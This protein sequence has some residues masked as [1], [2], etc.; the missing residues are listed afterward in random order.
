MPRITVTWI[1]FATLAIAAV[2]P[3]PRLGTVVFP[4]TGHAA[5]HRAFVEGVA[6]LHSFG[7]EQA[8]ESFRAA[9]KI[10][11]HFVMAYWGEAMTHNHP[12]WHSQDVEAGR[13]AL[14]ALAPTP[15]ARAAMAAT[16][17]ERGYLHAVDVLFGSG[18]DKIA[19]DRAYASAMKDLAASYPEDLEAQCFYALALLGTVPLGDRG[20]AVQLEAGAIAE[21]VL[22][23][24]A[25]HP[26]A[27]HLVIH[28]YDDPENAR[29]A[30]SAAHTY[31]HIAPDASHARHMPA[32]IFLQLGM[33][34]EAA[35]SDEAA[36]T[37]S[38][39]WVARQRFPLAMRDFH[40][41][42]WW[43]YELL[44]QGRFA[45]A[46]TTFAPVE[47]A[48]AQAASRGPSASQAPS[49]PL[50]EPDAVA[51]PDAMSLRNDL[52]SI[53][54]FY[55]LESGDWSMLKGRG[56]FDNIDELFAV[57]YSAARLGD[58]DRAKAALELL[59]KFLVTDKDEGRRPI[60]LV[61]ERELDGVIALAEKRVDA[62]VRSLQD[63]AAI[64]RRMRRPSA[65]PHP[66]KPAHELLGEA[67]L[68]VNRPR[69]AIDA[70]ERAL[71]WT[72][73]R[74]RA[75]LG[76]ARA[77]AKNGDAANAKKYYAQ[78]LKNWSRADA[79]RPE[80]PEARRAV[81]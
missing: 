45:K 10:D 17:R 1:V 57:G 67:L 9:Q 69:E 26:G 23:K 63:A 52:A 39:D 12:V 60:A 51:E 20:T 31:S 11:P 66:I 25:N 78:F 75:V 76:L 7:Y 77:Y 56:S 54:A 16:A 74:S 68:E 58:L 50:H 29:R 32:H 8:L 13:K 5:A 19:R 14:S 44:Q 81:R 37:A 27:A 71:S 80:L 70:F 64:E 59:Q 6:W 38:V 30:L 2:Q 21:R 72:P 18:G 15:E 73:N 61:M 28:A 65:R 55:V 46:R 40:S 35:A 4:A 42:S 34:N 3:P 41:L 49:M 47:E 22:A 24:N 36:F 62:A 43:S 33:W 79:G 48:I 53:R